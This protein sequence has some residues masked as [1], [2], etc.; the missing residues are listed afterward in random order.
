MK[1][2][3]LL[4]FLFLTSCVTTGGY[5]IL[6]PQVD[7]KAN[8]H[9]LSEAVKTKQRIGEKYGQYFDFFYGPRGAYYIVETSESGKLINLSDY[10]ITLSV[11]NDTAQN[12]EILSMALEDSQVLSGFGEV[13]EGNTQFELILNPIDS[14]INRPMKFNFNVNINFSL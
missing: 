2:F 5:K 6:L 13:R 7:K 11:N 12:P 9:N 10:D 3:I 1:Y 8:Q 14:S 4:L